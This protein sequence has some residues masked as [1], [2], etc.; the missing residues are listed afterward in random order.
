MQAQYLHLN[1]IATCLGQ[2]L[3]SQ[4]QRRSG[5][6]TSCCKASA[7]KDLPVGKQR[8]RLWIR[9]GLLRFIRGCQ[10]DQW[11]CTWRHWCSD[12]TRSIAAPCSSGPSLPYW[13]A[14]FGF[15][16]SGWYY[17]CMKSLTS[18]WDVRSRWTHHL[19]SSLYD[20][21]SWTASCFSFSINLCCCC[22]YFSESRSTCPD[23]CFTC[24]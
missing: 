8:L 6:Q 9:K 17:S 3:Q 14:S 11:Y 24:L 2:I 22:C 7:W 15:S 10:R 18:Y 13:L 20:R 19:N 5:R 4:C 21:V 1:W 23:C 12:Y 16:T